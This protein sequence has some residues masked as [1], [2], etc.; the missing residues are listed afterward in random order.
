L[1]TV[2]PV[3]EASACERPAGVK[4]A[5]AT[6]SAPMTCEPG[7]HFDPIDGGSC[8]RCPTGYDRTAARVD[9]GDA[10]K[11]NTMQWRSA[12]YREPGLFQLDGAA[13]VLRAITELN[14]PLVRS[15]LDAVAR[16]LSAQTGTPI[17]QVRAEQKNIFVNQPQASLVAQAAVFTRLMA[18]IAEPTRASAIEKRL[19]ES[20]RKHVIAKRSYIATDMLNAYYAWKQSDDYWRDQYNLNRGLAGTMYYGTVPPSFNKLGMAAT[21]GI[22]AT[23]TATSMAIDASFAALQFAKAAQRLPILGDLL[24]VALSAAG[25]GWTPA[26]SGETIALFTVRSAG[27]VALSQAI[28]QLLTYAA[29][30]P[31]WTIVSSGVATSVPMAALSTAGPQIIVAGGM[32]L[33]SIAIDQFIQITEAEPKLKNA[34]LNAGA[35]PDLSRMSKTKDGV[36]QLETYWSYAVGPEVHPGDAFVK[37]WGPLANT[38]MAAM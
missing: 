10:C 1:R 6:K 29:Q 15:S 8:Y 7:D 17:E 30:I 12:P 13:E 5:S 32:I 2:F 34:V 14:V 16:H 19:V 20:F 28:G 3:H 22:L 23:A 31:A 24:G 38:R 9:A 18:A 27:E 33:A 36:L 21:T 25:G 35:D 11:T 4:F 37:A 26:T